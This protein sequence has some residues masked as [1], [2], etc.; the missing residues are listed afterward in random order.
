MKRNRFKGIANLLICMAVTGLLCFPK[1]EVRA[2]EAGDG[3]GLVAGVD[4]Y[5]NFVTMASAVI[6]Y[7]DDDVY[8]AV[9]TDI[10][11]ETVS[12]YILVDGAGQQDIEFVESNSDVYVYIFSPSG[13]SADSSFLPV[14]SAYEGETETFVYLSYDGES[15]EYMY[16]D[17]EI[18]GVEQNGETYCY[19]FEL[20]DDLDENGMLPGALVNE[21][22]YLTAVVTENGDMWAVA[23]DSS[24]WNQTQSQTYIIIA[25]VAVA[26]IAFLLLR[27]KNGGAQA[28]ESGSSDFPDLTN[29]YQAAPAPDIPNSYQAAPAPN[30]PNSYSAVTA[31]TEPLNMGTPVAAAFGSS[32]RLVAAGGP[33]KGREYAPANGTLVFG[34]EKTSN[35][36]FP[37]ETPGI[38]RNHCRVY[39]NGSHMM[40]EDLGSTYG[41]VLK[42]YGKLKPN[43]PVEVIKG[44]SFYLGD[45]GNLF[46]VQ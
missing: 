45:Q 1:T 38:S 18:T 17:V 41:T 22:G 31:A 43:V 46:L 25:V 20:Q 26:V 39:Q 5:G 15:I 30:L 19:T 13:G 7:D 2:Y 44:D 11:D 27:K 16:A 40:L 36:C 8:V 37:A 6:Y 24:E 21:D 42:G 23:Y 10:Y 3:V 32:L 34:R 9:G 12:E 35:V 29:S 4:S 33:L 28:E 14:A